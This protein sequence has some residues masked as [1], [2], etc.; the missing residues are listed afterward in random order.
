VSDTVLLTGA[1]GFLGMKI[2]ARL[3]ER[4]D[5]EVGAGLPDG[6]SDRVSPA[7]QA[8]GPAAG[9]PTAGCAARSAGSPHV[10]KN[11]RAAGA[12]SGRANRNP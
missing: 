12:S 11:S 2:L 4:T 6:W 7:D 1:T 3:L 8:D 9:G 5:S 10:A